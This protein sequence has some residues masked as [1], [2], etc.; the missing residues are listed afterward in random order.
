MMKKA[1]RIRRPDYASGPLSDEER[2]AMKAIADLWIKRAMRTEPIEPEK[3]IPAIKGIYAVAGLKEPRVVIAPSPM[4]MAFAYGASVAIWH[5]RATTGYTIDAILAAA[6]AVIAATEDA[7]E[8]A[9]WAAAR[10]AIVPTVAINADIWTATYNIMSATGTAANHAIDS[11]IRAAMWATTETVVTAATIDSAA[12]IEDATR[13][14]I[15][16]GVTAAAKAC[17]SMAGQFGID[18]ARRW[19]SAHQ[20]GNMS[21]G[22]NAYLAAA[23]DVLGL[24]LPEHENYAYL[25]QADIHGGFRVMHPEFCIV[26]DFPEFIHVDEQNRPHCETGPSHRWR[27][28]WSIYHWH[29]TRIPAEWIEDK[30]SLTPRIALGKRDGNRRA[31]AIQIID[32]ARKGNGG[33]G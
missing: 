15:K 2:A 5:T 32:W 6:M 17:F 7:T 23:R 8:T 20:R 28:G 22:Y 30:A 31:A 16:A 27:D 3:I 4:A 24:R 14:A 33:V 1:E 21:V 10:T 18:C 29:G 26:S 11:A 9:T 19:I 12:A 13:A 25:E